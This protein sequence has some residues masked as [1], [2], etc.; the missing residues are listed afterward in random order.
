MAIRCRGNAQRVPAL[1]QV[2][3]AVTKK[4]QKKTQ[5]KG[6]HQAPALSDKLW[7]TWLKFIKDHA[8]PRMFLIVFMTGAFGLRA[9]EA[10]AL[11]REDLQLDAQEPYVHVTGESHGAAKSPGQVYISAKNLK[12]LRAALDQG[13]TAKRAVNSKHG[14]TTRKQIYKIPD[15]GFLF[16]SRAGAAT[17]HV[18]YQAVYHSV[19]DL[20]PKFLEELKKNGQPNF[21][22]LAKIRPH[23]GRASGIT[24]LMSAGLSLGV[25]MKWARHAPGSVKVHLRNGQLTHSD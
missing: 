18:T 17:K 19:T 10:V 5:K 25:T 6:P 4:A 9:G 3:K 16:R 2:M 22:E 15:E 23:S 20:A 24:T 11:K 14:I 1:T 21:P 13:I 8:G 7:D 12:I